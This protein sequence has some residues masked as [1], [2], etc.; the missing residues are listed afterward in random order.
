[1][2]PYCRD[3]SNVTPFFVCVVKE[4]SERMPGVGLQCGTD[5]D[6]RRKF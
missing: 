3:Q 6:A 4:K 1:M 5:G 2:Y